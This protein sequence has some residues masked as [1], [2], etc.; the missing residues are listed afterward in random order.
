[1]YPT[2][3][4]RF[5]EAVDQH[6]NPRALLYKVQDTWQPISSAEFLRRVAGLSHALRNLA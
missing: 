5:L 3:T 6:P 2:L 1:M 4:Q